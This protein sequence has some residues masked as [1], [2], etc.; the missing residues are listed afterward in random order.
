MEVS[1]INAKGEIIAINV[2]THKDRV[3]VE[4]S[5]KQVE[6]IKCNKRYVLTIIKILNIEIAYKKELSKVIYMQNQ[7]INGAL[8]CNFNL[9]ELN[10]A[11]ICDK[12]ALDRKTTNAI[13]NKILKATYNKLKGL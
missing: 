5:C 7:G 12:Y 1:H 11:D 6:S 9:S 10:V 2:P 13:H 8:D 4:K 3:Q